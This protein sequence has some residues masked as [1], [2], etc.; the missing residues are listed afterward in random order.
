MRISEIPGLMPT[1]VPIVTGLLTRQ[2]ECCTEQQ[3]WDIARGM[4]TPS[5]RLHLESCAD[6]QQ[7]VQS[8][9]GG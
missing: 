6:C 7:R 9:P 5:A 4:G 2:V 1:D 8:V 3:L